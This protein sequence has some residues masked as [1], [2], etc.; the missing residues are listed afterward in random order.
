[1]QMNLEI[2]CIFVIALST[3]VKLSLCHD[4]FNTRPTMY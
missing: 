4:E 1:M 2:E 3:V